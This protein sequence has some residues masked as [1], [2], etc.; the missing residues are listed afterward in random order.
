MLR[1]LALSVLSAALV[2][3]SCGGADAFYTSGG[4]KDAAR[5]KDLFSLLHDPALKDEELFAVT[6]EISQS[7][8][9]RED[10]GRLVTFL[11]GR[12]SADP[13]NLYNA[14]YMLTIAYAYS[15]RGAAPVANL[16]FDRIVKNYPDLLVKGE[17]IHRTCL[18]RLVETSGSP[19]RR[20]DCRKELIARFPDAIDMGKTLFLLGKDY[21]ELGEWDSAVDAYRRFLP[22]FGADIPG[23]PD[24]VRYARL[25]IDLTLIPKTWTY[26]RLEDLVADLKDA[27][28]N[29]K[30]AKLQKIRAKVGFF[31]MDWRQDESEGNSNVVF[32]FGAFMPSGR[33]AFADALDPSSSAREAFL[34]TWGWADRIST[35]YLVMRK[36]NFPADPEVHGR[37]EWIGIYYGEKVQ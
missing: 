8:L 33:I 11:T 36:I 22:F 16:Y 3:S 18:E 13:E 19:E 27:L 5:L 37:W 4:G 30:L 23:H 29:G 10:Y 35:W 2:L 24:A 14:Q 26:E 12:I 17:S 7:M 28:A 31:A 9:A 6:Q 25:L 21:E 32:E 20:V 1:P 34:R 15:L